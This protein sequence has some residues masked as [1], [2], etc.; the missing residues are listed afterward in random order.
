M[1]QIYATTDSLDLLAAVRAARTAI[2]SGE[3][4]VMPTDTVYG[5]A[6]DAFS[7]Q[8]VQRLLDAK[9]RTR[10]TP[11]P[12]LVANHETLD[13]LAENVH[14]LARQLFERFAPGPLTVIL[15]ARGSLQWDLGDTN[16]TVALRIP[17]SRLA[18]ELLKE[19]GPLAVSSANKHGEPAATTAEEALAALGDDVGVFLDGGP[20][21]GEASTIVDATP[22][23]RGEPARIVRQGALSRALIEEVLGDKL[24]PVDPVEPAGDPSQETVALSSPAAE[25]AEET[26]SRSEPAA[27][28]ES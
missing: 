2:A 22:L 5:I 11:P 7:A 10:A 4:I 14:P 17:D 6:A 25:P 15:Q 28:H 8:A 1:G 27:G 20:A 13:A 3:V 21:G 16:G 24:A 12:V 23:T 26:P 9:G 18:R 19:T